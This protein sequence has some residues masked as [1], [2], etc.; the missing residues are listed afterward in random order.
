[1]I[2]L[3]IAIPKAH[4]LVVVLEIIGAT[5]VLLIL[6]PLAF[7]LL[8]ISKGVDAVALALALDV[9]ALVNIPILING[10]TLSMR[11]SI[12]PVTSGIS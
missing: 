2:L 5:P 9:V 6:Q 11:L 1:M 12:L 4:V 3:I 8:A 10:T 7:I